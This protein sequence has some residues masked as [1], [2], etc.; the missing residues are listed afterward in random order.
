MIPLHHDRY[1]TFRFSDDRIIPRFHLD[2]V[3]PG[4]RV[5]VFRYDAAT[6][7]RLERLASATVGEGGWVGLPEP[8]VMRSGEGFV[9]V[10]EGEN[11]CAE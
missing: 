3:A 2:G 1:F 4:V 7:T 6:E 8:L 9:V 11:T 10:P 5:S